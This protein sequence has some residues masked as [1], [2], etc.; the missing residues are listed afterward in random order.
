[1]SGVI[2][3][4]GFSYGHSAQGGDRNPPVPQIRVEQVEPTCPLSN[5][6]QRSGS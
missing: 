5:N 1:V 6:K 2:F 4:A 3:G